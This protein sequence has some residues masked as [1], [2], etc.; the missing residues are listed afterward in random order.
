[1][2]AIAMVVRC[3][4]RQQGDGP[5][6]TAS[7]GVETVSSDLCLPG[8]DRGLV[9]HLPLDTTDTVTVYDF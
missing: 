9:G 6:P 2:N 8:E 5:P 7:R 4:I 3:A 1:M